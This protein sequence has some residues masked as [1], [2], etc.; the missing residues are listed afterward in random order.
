MSSTNLSDCQENLENL[1]KS[2]KSKLTD[3]EYNALLVQT[4][5]LIVRAY[6]IGR[7]EGISEGQSNAQW[8]RD[9]RNGQQMGQ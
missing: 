7:R 2:V 8:E 9:A 6:S 3:V 4:N 5:L 1:I